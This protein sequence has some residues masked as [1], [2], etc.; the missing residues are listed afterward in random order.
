MVVGARP[1]LRRP[2]D[3]VFRGTALFPAPRRSAGCADGR[4]GVIGVAALMRLR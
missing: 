2:R 4:L 3:A 1:V